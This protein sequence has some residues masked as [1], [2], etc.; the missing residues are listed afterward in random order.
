MKRESGTY[1][2]GGKGSCCVFVL[3]SVEK[4]ESEWQKAPWG[5][6]ELL[7]RHQQT[8]HSTEAAKKQAQT[9]FQVLFFN[10]DF[11]PIITNFCLYSTTC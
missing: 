1:R 10:S 9:L 4:L 5:S 7:H 11:S 8:H 6:G 3:L 2:D